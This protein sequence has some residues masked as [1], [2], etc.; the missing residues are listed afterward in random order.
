MYFVSN[1]CL[2]AFAQSHTEYNK[3]A[4]PSLGGMQEAFHTCRHTAWALGLD[5]VHRYQQ[6]GF[7]KEKYKLESIQIK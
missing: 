6:P 3:M 4:P 5:L 2:P 7:K 1:I